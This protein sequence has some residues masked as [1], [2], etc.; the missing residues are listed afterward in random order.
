TNPPM[1]VEA[2]SFWPELRARGGIAPGR[3]G[4]W[5][6]R[7][8][9]FTL[10]AWY[11]SQRFM[12]STELLNVSRAIVVGV[13][14]VIAVGVAQHLSH[15]TA[16]LWLYE[17]L[18]WTRVVPLAGPFVNP[19]QAGAYVGLGAVLAASGVHYSRERNARLI[20]A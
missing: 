12:R 16:V 17:P 9:T 18:D 1:A 14:L 4:L 13:L 5:V 8:L 19:N 7:T 15:A 6:I 11:A 20:Y 3:A 2:W 10:S